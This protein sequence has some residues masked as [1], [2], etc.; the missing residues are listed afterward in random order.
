MTNKIENQILG[1]ICK[2][3]KVKKNDLIKKNEFKKFEEWDSL[4]HLEIISMLDKVLGKKI[5]KINNISQVDSVKK[6]LTIVKK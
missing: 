3:L 4:K 2:I 1:K 6:I 5:N